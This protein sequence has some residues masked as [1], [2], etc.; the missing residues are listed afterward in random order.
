MS[1]RTLWLRLQLVPP[2]LDPFSAAVPESMR[3]AVATGDVASCAPPARPAPK[4]RPGEPQS[5]QP[6][7]TKREAAALAYGPGTE[8]SGDPVLRTGSRRNHENRGEPGVVS[9]KA[10]GFAVPV[11]GGE[12]APVIA[13]PHGSAVVLRRKPY[14]CPPA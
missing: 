14:R 9:L 4:D 2:V 3:T 11:V 5:T 12:L 7:S 13:R 1:R 8:R 6:W 10:P